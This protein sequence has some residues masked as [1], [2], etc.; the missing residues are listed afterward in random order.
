M[1]ANLMSVHHLHCRVCMFLILLSYRQQVLEVSNASTVIEMILIF[2]HLL[3]YFDV[4]PENQKLSICANV[5]CFCQRGSYRYKQR[6]IKHIY[7]LN[8][9]FGI[10]STK[11]K[12]TIEQ[13]FLSHVSIQLL[14]QLLKVILMNLWKEPSCGLKYIYF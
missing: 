4:N 1:M 8:K 5:Y 9:M 3:K 7:I 14:L 11:N 2:H 10:C 13:V 12:K 6:I